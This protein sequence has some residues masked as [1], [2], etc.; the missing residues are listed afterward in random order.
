MRSKLIQIWQKFRS[1]KLNII[2][3]SSI[4]LIFL[5]SLVYFKNDTNYIEYGDYKQLLEQNLIEKAHV[6]G[7]K[8]Y[9]TYKGRKFIILKDLVNLKDLEIPITSSLEADTTPFILYL[10]VITFTFILLAYFLQSFLNVKKKEL[11]LVLKQKSASINESAISPANSDIRF[12]DIAGISEVKDDLIQ[13]VDFLKNPAKYRDF[14]IKLPKGVLMVGAPGVGKTYI[15]KAVAGEAGVPFFYQSGSNFAEIYVGVGAKK[16]RDLFAVAK[17]NAPSIVFIDEIDAVG[18]SRGNGRNDELESTLNQLLTEMDG[19]ESNSGVIVIAATNKIDMI[20]EALLRPGR[21]DRRIFISLPNFKDRMEIL[22]IYLRDKKCDLDISKVSR[23]SVG[24]SGAGIATLVNEA[25]INALNRGSSVIGLVDFESVKDRVLL[26]SKREK[27]LSEYEKEIQAFY[28]AAKALSAFWYSVE[29]DKI[30]LLDDKFIKTDAEIESKSV[31]LNRIK[32]LLSGMA[33][34]KIYKNDGYTNS[35]ND[36]KEA[37]ILA[38]DMVFEYS[39]GEYLLPNEGEIN[40]ILT[41]CFDEVSEIL[42]TKQRELLE[43]SK[44]IFVYEFVGFEK[45]K[46]IFDLEFKEEK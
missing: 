18:K 10:I 40:K 38:R 16:V 22:K 44:Q 15:A 36:T 17:Q 13:I 25:A 28:Q 37:L 12:K 34:L 9:I 30:A 7:D 11:N 19:F 2:L 45:V 3:F 26:G 27:I 32:V 29:F 43:I 14:G 46:E 5:L 4:V 33:A 39:M 8:L 31:I 23:M 6:E 21:F 1:S 35:A 41:I 20:D 24:F 42:R